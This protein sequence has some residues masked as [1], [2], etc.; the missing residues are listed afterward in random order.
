MLS[1]A[2]MVSAAAVAAI[3]TPA[4][5]AD[6]PVKDKISFCHWTNGGHY[7]YLTTALEA[8]FNS[9]HIDHQGGR[10]IYPA[11]SV[12]KQGKPHPWAAQGDQSLLKPGCGDVLPPP[13]PDALASAT[14]NNDQT[15]DRP[16]TVTFSLT[17]ATWKDAADTSD[18]SRDA[19]ADDGHVFADGD[20]QLTVTYTANP[21]KSGP[22]CAV[23]PL[24]D[25]VASA[26]ANNDQTC[27]RAGTVTFSLT[28]A[29]WKDAGDTSDGS[30]DAVADA[31]HVFAGGGT[32]MTVTYTANPKK[33]GPACPV[34]LASVGVAAP[35][36]TGPTCT[37]PGKLSYSDAVGYTWNRTEDHG[38]VVLTAMPTAGFTLTGTTSWT[39]TAAQL[40]QLSGAQAC[41][42]MSTPVVTPPAV[43]PPKVEG[44]KHT[45]P[46]KAP[47]VT[48]VVKGIKQ[49]AAPVLP[50]TG[51]EASLYGAAGVLLLLVGSGLVLATRREDQG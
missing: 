2:T 39:F 23:A 13:A 26:T 29:S 27:D 4:A 28:N 45:A 47:T 34:V 36:L 25:A 15:C 31:G 5:S 51:T 16:G 35:V 48:P 19:V 9:G 18:G 43:I 17:H 21:K 40:D 30:R 46:P 38:N 20:T 1:I 37:A 22:E 6:P 3:G 49:E 42:P 44:V 10:D 50:R 12:T 14:A 11:G 32:E 33:S 8:F 41:P 24:K 7:E